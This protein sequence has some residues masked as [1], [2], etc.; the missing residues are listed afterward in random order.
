MRRGT[1]PLPLAIRCG[2]ALALGA[3]SLDAAV[4]QDLVS[5]PAPASVRFVGEGSAGISAI[6]SLSA[7]DLQLLAALQSPLTLDEILQRGLPFR[8][9]QLQS[10][11]RAGVLAQDGVAF[12]SLLALLGDADVAALRHSLDGIAAGVAGDV[13]VELAS[14][15]AAL[16][17]TRN[18][19]ALAALVNWILRERVWQQLL[20]TAAI[21]VP[22]LVA[23]QRAAAPERGWYGVLWLSPVVG[24]AQRAATIGGSERALLASW[25]SA[26][27][28]VPGQ[29]AAQFLAGLSA[30]GRR[31][32]HPERLPTLQG[33]GLVS[34]AGDVRIPTL[35][36]SPQADG[37]I[38]AEVDQLTSAFATSVA[39]HLA[40]AELPLPLAASD[41]AGV[42]TIAYVELVPLL[43]AELLRTGYP[44]ALADTPPASKS[45]TRTGGE[46]VIPIRP[47]ERAATLPSISAIVW[48]GLNVPAP[49]YPIAWE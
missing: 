29:E 47:Q 2:C 38:A 33:A 36:W 16:D 24:L 14:L 40:V 32:D 7:E 27:T 39:A 46:F 1:T 26:A 6:D 21:D 28:P 3:S 42:R 19:A 25:N 48:R 34:A 43:I 12:R 5:V 17:G 41:V 18:G 13:A 35:D 31:V 23:G 30:D 37:S 10:L 49:A 22:G 44:I 20:T 8:T 4:A 45:T 15:Q 11:Q 9:A